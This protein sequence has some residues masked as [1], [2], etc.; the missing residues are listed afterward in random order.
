MSNSLPWD[1]IATPERDY[2]VRLIPDGSV[3]PAY[4]GKDVQGKLLFLISLTGDHRNLFEQEKVTVK[5]VDTDLR[6]DTATDCQLLVLTLDRQVDSDLFHALCKSLFHSLKEVHRPDVAISVAMQ[7]LKRWRTFL[8]GQNSRLL[9]IQE[10]RGLFAELVFLNKLLEVGLNPASAVMAWTGPEWVHQDFIYSGRAVEVKALSSSDRST[11]R[12][13]SEDQLE[14]IEEKLY[15]LTLTLQDSRDNTVALSLNA[16]VT[17]IRDLLQ[18]ESLESFDNKLAANGYAPHHEYETPKLVTTS[19][20]AYL[21]EKDFPKVVRSM[22]PAGVRSVS[23]QLELEKIE[24]FSCA[25]ET[26]L[27]AL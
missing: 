9:T 4:W 23:Y 20:K 2:N 19:K 17:H 22:L 10:H 21:V 15:L 27:E 13:S 16:L 6:Q 26:L 24:P 5:G 8:S 12:I 7:H 3:I 18:G 14:S 11:V 1:E 25:F